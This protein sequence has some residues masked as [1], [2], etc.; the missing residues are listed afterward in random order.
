MAAA[1]GKQSLYAD[2][3]IILEEIMSSLICPKCKYQTVGNEVYC[4]KCGTKLEQ[5]KFFCKKCGSELAPDDNF[6]TQCGSKRNANNN[7]ASDLSL[8][9][10]I[11]S[12]VTGFK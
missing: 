3:N 10:A 7:P 2:I 1:T 4:C 9:L 11:A 8:G 6:C 12:I 5:E